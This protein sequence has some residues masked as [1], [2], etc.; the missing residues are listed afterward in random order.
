MRRDHNEREDEFR[1]QYQQQESRFRE[2]IERVRN[3][4]ANALPANK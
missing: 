2:E 4:N 1:R 3:E